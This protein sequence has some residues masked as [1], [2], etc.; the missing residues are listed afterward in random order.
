MS[1]PYHAD[2]EVTARALAELRARAAAQIATVARLRAER[3]AA[4]EEVKGLEATFFASI[5]EQLARVYDAS[6][7]LVLA[8]QEARALALDIYLNDPTS[9]SPVPGAKIRVTRQAKYDATA[10]LEWAKREMRVAV[11]PES[12][13]TKQ[14][15][16]FLLGLDTP[17]A[18]TFYH[19]IIETPT[20]A[21]DKVLP[22]P[23]E[24]TA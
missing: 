16:R 22:T 6:Q 12:L 4:D 24:A 15:D 13:D 3:E 21:L 18:V 11:V 17:N 5:E 14:M 8:E 9:K 7:R 2:P 23:T 20:V 10:A 19:R 1:V